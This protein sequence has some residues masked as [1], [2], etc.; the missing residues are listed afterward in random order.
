MGN[1]YYSVLFELCKEFN[2]LY[3]TV[4]H[5][6]IKASNLIWLKLRTVANVHEHCNNWVLISIIRIRALYKPRE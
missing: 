4:M 3:Y 6:Y 5:I 2:I 1:K